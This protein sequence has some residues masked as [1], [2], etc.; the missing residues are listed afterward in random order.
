[1]NVKIVGKNLK[2][3]EKT[4][5]L[6]ESIW[7]AKPNVDLVSQVVNVYRSNQRCSNASA[8]DRGD[9]SGG[10]KKPWR[11]KGTGR[12]R[13]GSTRSPIWVGGGVVFGPTGRNWKRS[14]NRKMKLGALAS[15]LSDRLSKGDVYFVDSA[16]FARDLFSDI[17]SA[18]VIT[19]NKEAYLRVRNLDGVN[20]GDPADVNVIDAMYGKKLFID[21]DSLSALEGRYTNGK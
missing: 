12:A 1:M 15:V 9:V 21:V 6:N 13:H 2:E 20:V 14:V 18:F 16:N 4:V 10:G 3:T 11:Q 17:K 7:S 8:K 19:S 5:T